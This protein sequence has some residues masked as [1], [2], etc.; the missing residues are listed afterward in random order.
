MKHLLLFGNEFRS[1]TLKGFEVLLKS[2]SIE[3]KSGSVMTTFGTERENSTKKMISRYGT[4]DLN[5]GSK[6]VM[7][8]CVCQMEVKFQK[9][10]EC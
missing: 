10:L 7:R 6:A 9:V 1:H 3:W 2:L 4:I 8:G 5:R